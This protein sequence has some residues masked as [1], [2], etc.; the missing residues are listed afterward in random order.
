MNQ[1]FCAC[2]AGAV[3]RDPKPPVLNPASTLGLRL[4]APLEL[5]A[6]LTLNSLDIQDGIVRIDVT[7]PQD[8]WFAIGWDAFSMDNAYATVI[9]LN[10]PSIRPP[11]DYF[12]IGDKG[13]RD[14]FEGW[15]DVRCQQALNDYC[16]YV[17]D[18]TPVTGVYWFSCAL[19]NST[20]Q[21]TN[22]YSSSDPNTFD[23]K[24]ASRVPCKGGKASPY[25]PMSVG[26]YRLSFNPRGFTKLPQTVQVE[27]TLV[28]NGQFRIVFSRNISGP[29]PFPNSTSMPLI[30]SLG[31]QQ[32]FGIPR[33]KT[34]PIKHMKKSET[35]VTMNLV[36]IYPVCLS[37]ATSTLP[38][39]LV[40][41]MSALFA[42]FSFNNN[43][44]K[45]V[46]MGVMLL[47][48]FVR[49]SSAH[50]WVNVP[51]RAQIAAVTVPCQQRVDPAPHL[52]VAPG[53][54]FQLEWST[55]HG[56]TPTAWTYWVFLKEE[57]FN[58]LIDITDSNLEDYLDKAP[59]ASV[60]TGDQWTRRHLAPL[61]HANP[62]CVNCNNF[63]QFPT[64]FQSTLRAGDARFIQRNPIA[65]KK[66]LQWWHQD[67]QQYWYP[68]SET[69]GDK[70]AQYKS[71]KYPWIISVHKFHVPNH[72][73][74]EYDM[75]TFT[76]P[77]MGSGNYIAHFKW[78]GYRDCTDVHLMANVPSVANPWGLVE[79][80]N[81]S[82]TFARLDHCE[83]TYVLNPSTR[84][85][86]MT[87]TNASQ[88]LADCLKKDGTFGCTGVQAVLRQNPQGTLPYTENF[89]A[90]LYTNIPANGVFPP[91]ENGPCDSRTIHKRAP[92][93]DLNPM[94]TAADVGTDPTSYICY[95]LTP[96]RDQDF[97]VEEDYVITTDP[98]DPGFY[99]TCWVRLAPG[100]FL[101]SPA[102]VVP[103]PVWRVG[104]QCVSCDWLVD[105]YPTFPLESAIPWK[106][107]LTTIVE[108]ATPREPQDASPIRRSW[109]EAVGPAAVP[110]LLMAWNVP[111]RATRVF[112][113]S[114][115]H[116]NVKMAF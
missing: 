100:G 57:H 53:Q 43:N 58:R 88:C 73:P 46:V 45:H 66:S 42:G 4:P 29:N 113:C 32:F 33:G 91:P 22:A 3:V 44:N 25:L 86:T 71:E 68:A 60:F 11:Q 74:D 109:R 108:I 89:P 10:D 9:W 23:A 8:R 14:G 52:Q 105:R 48:L 114:G 47:A 112:C 75:A 38:S 15:Y 37:P 84:C 77:N 34:A 27:R 2:R 76:F 104:E 103:K 56:E 61:D 106:D 13:Y 35:S 67:V 110:R 78:G 54:T 26:E 5:D 98:K 107:A 24:L 17:G 63:T 64:I 111:L 96:Y 99:S 83:F 102:P 36:P 1:Q 94:C 20:N 28:D 69:N 90:K 85:R 19:A 18:K 92:C 59:P 51:S 30:W 62:G 21:G 101:P 49:P 7:G 6:E 87:G 55:G 41:L 95:G 12:G 93:G 70:R 116:V 39:L 82:S 31:V 65:V 40:L 80:A 115:V 50:N 72:W 81:L 16:R 79:S 97:Q